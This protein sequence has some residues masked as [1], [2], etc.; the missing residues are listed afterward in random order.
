MHGLSRHIPE[1]VKLQVRQRS[2]FGCI[3]CRSALYNYEHIEPEFKDAREHD[4]S[5]I[6]L[7]CPS[8]HSLVTKG[9]IPKSEILN[10]Y[11]ITRSSAF[12]T[13]PVD[14]EFFQCYSENVTVKMGGATFENFTSIINVDGID[15]LSY[16]LDQ[17]TKKYVVS[18]RFFGASGNELFE[19]VDNQWIG[20]LDL[21]DVEQVGKRL[22]VKES[23]GHTS[24]KA[25]KNNKESILEIEDLNM[26]IGN[27]H[28]IVNNGV[29]IVGQKDR[30]S[31]ENIYIEVGARFRN[32]QCGL[33]LDS[34]Q[35]KKICVGNV[36]AIGGKGLTMDGTGIWFGFGAAPIMLHEVKVYGNCN[37]KCIDKTVV[38]SVEPKSDQNY[39]IVGVLETQIVKHPMWLEEKFSL[40]GQSISEKPFSWGIIE[41]S[42]KGDVELFHISRQEGQDLYKNSGFIGFYA[43]DVMSYDWSDKIFEVA[44]RAESEYGFYEERVKKCDVGERE[45]VS[46]VD[47]QTGK[48]YWP[49]SFVGTI[50][51]KGL[52]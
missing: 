28:I 45:V 1:S 40:N 4:A 34:S 5:R 26:K 3:R 21:W 44:V 52:N 25:I 8:C 50:P 23:I 33:Y 49:Q 27:F 19:I 9:R 32:G 14:D 35:K 39:F 7:L 51:W 46:E 12:T 38:K 48:P 42:D 13:P 30:Y 43:D 29:I 24:F 17:I 6:A 2:A 37:R 20:N 18:G 22:T 15:I 47:S 36:K 31:L 10:L 11:K 16:R 41:S